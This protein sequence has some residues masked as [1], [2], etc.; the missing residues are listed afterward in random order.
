[1]N[2][3]KFNFEIFIFYVTK[4]FDFKFLQLNTFFNGLFSLE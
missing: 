4:K 3:N 1:M 2:E